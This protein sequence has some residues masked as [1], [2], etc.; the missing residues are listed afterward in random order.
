MAFVKLK[1]NIIS[2]LVVIG[3]SFS[4][5]S[6]QEIVETIPLV[7]DGTNTSCVDIGINM[8]TN[9]VYITTLYPHPKLLV[10]DGTSREI[11]STLPIG[12]RGPS[13]LAIDEKQNVVYVANNYE[14]KIYIID[15][16]A[17]TVKRIITYPNFVGGDPREMTFDPVLNKIFIANC[18][19]YG[20]DGKNSL[21]VL[22]CNS[23]SVLYTSFNDVGKWPEGIATNA[24]WGRIYV[25]NSGHGNISIIDSDNYSLLQFLQLGGKP[26]DI[27][28]D[29][30]RNLLYVP[31]VEGTLSIIDEIDL[32]ISRLMLGGKPAD[33]A[34]YPSKNAIY[35]I[36]WQGN[37]WKIQN[38]DITKILQ[39]G[40]QP[41]SICV[42][43]VR[44]IIYAIQRDAYS[45]NWPG[46]L[47]VIEES[48][49]Y[50]EPYT[51]SQ[52]Y[53]FAL[54]QNYPNPFNT[55]TVIQYQLP[56]RTHVTLKV[57]DLTGHEVQTLIDD[58]KETGVHKTEWNG[59]NNRGHTV[60]SGL[61]MIRIVAE[62][63]VQSKK[64][65]RLN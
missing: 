55:T 60:G 15:A 51:N 42:D 20:E 38:N 47:V 10:L 24:S 41:Q 22:D 19:W 39:I 53:S 35:V 1:K 37:F 46:T 4:N 65:V 13:H 57:Y 40:G 8:S 5:V 36:G 29:D 9:K 14:D 54:Y 27:A 3:L 17:D 6:S 43:T 18:A 16:N 48:T 21:T 32:S 28:R 64:I 30:T 31:S 26:Y 2:L 62:K 49:H 61:Y 7:V 34:V 63:F 44:N 45:L 23:D 12:Q 33:A 11:I 50:Q 59:L 56:H 52:S 58:V 25:A